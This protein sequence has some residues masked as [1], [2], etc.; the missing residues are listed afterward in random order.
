ME[1]AGRRHAAS[2]G[3]SA[4]F[5]GA[6]GDWIC[7]LAGQSCA[8]DRQCER[9]G[10]LLASLDDLAVVRAVGFRDGDR[11]EIPLFLMHVEGCRGDGCDPA[12]GGRSATW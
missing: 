10:D 1:C 8:D 11:G 2:V 7:H 9:R 12:S 5:G 4:V 6:R 3:L